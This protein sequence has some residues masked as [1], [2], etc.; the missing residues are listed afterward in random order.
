MALLQAGMDDIMPLTSSATPAR[1]TTAVR[2]A[3]ELSIIVPTFNERTNVPL[4][5]SGWN[6]CLPHTTGKSCSSTTTR[7]TAPPPPRERSAKAIAACA[8]FAASAADVLP[9]PA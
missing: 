9:A 3:P 1:P 2:P 6:A 8:V 4:W 7:L 5:S